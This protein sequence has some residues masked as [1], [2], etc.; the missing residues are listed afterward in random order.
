MGS[1]RPLLESDDRSNFESGDAHLDRFFRVYAGQNQFRH[2]VSVTYVFAEEAEILGY[3]TVAGGEMT[4][5]RLP[6]GAKK[7]PRYPLPILRVGRLA[8]SR[9][10][11][12]AGIGAQL[13]R[14]ALGL[15]VSMAGTTGCVGVLVDPKTGA[16][17]FYQRFGFERVHV[18]EGEILTGSSYVSQF[19]ALAKI[20]AALP[21]S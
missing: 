15:A 12:G 5:D 7:F 6:R 3:V 2:H 11:R 10:A 16:E 14:H 18:L 9:S 21:A 20:H 4:V 8:V 19:L 17:G 1:I 13:L